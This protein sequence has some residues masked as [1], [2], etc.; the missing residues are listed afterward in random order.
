MSFSLSL[1]SLLS[2]YFF[3]FTSAISLYLYRSFTHTHTH[4]HTHTLSPHGIQVFED[5]YKSPQSVIVVDDIE[6]LLDY[7]PIGPRFS[8]T[9][10]QCL[11]VLFKKA[12]K[13]V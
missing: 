6:R 8:N 4:T 11:L 3:V 2:A 1:S 13:Q 9:V 12:P 5:A 7:V 10:L